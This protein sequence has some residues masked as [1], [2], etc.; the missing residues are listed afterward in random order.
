MSQIFK[1]YLTDFKGDEAERALKERARMDKD[2]HL[3]KDP[4][5]ELRATRERAAG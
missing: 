5:A 1:K 3:K 2:K 4:A